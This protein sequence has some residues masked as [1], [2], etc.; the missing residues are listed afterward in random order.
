M[1]ICALEALFAFIGRVRWNDGL[2]GSWGI[3]ALSKYK[4]ETGT[5]GKE[6]LIIDAG[7][8]E[9]LDEIVGPD[10]KGELNG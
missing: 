4:G 8:V 1:T 10:F 5:S 7:F 3:K 2:C 9:K 6:V